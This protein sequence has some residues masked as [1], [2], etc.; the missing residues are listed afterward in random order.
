MR[1][2]LLII[3]LTVFLLPLSLNAQVDSEKSDRGQKSMQ[4]QRGKKDKRRQRRQQSQRQRQLDPAKV[5]KRFDQNQ[6]G[7]IAP[8]ELPERIRDRMTV[9]D[10]NADGVIDGAEFKTHIEKTKKKRGKGKGQGKGKEQGKAAQRNKLSLR[11]PENLNAEQV[12]SQLDRDGSGALEKSEMPKIMASKLDKIDSDGNA[13][14]SMTEL[15]SA[16]E[17]LKAK[18]MDAGKGRY[19]TDSSSSKGQVPKRPGAGNDSS[20]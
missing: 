11:Q 17:K 5:F 4:Q 7:V 9:A 8:D 14:V 6:D 10:T 20:S 19:S 13:E 18:A 12:M 15:R 16:I 2:S 3:L 1:T